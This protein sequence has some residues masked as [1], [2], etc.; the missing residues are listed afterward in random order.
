VA[1]RLCPHPIESERTEEL[2]ADPNCDEGRLGAQETCPS[3]GAPLW[4]AP[5]DIGVAVVEGA[6]ERVSIRVELPSPAQAARTAA[7]PQRP[8]D[9][10]PVGGHRV[11]S[12]VVARPALPAVL[13]QQPAVRAVA[14]VGVGAV[15]LSVSVRLLRAWLARPR[16]ARSLVA[17]AM[18]ALAELRPRDGGGSQTPGRSMA[19]GAELVETVV[20]VERVVRRRQG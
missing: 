7:Y 3:C 4:A 1:E 16:A 18:P 9:G 10:V 19:R 13:W 20:Y 6:A 15:A 17:S 11:T 12:L 8:T 2:V 5:G 14:E